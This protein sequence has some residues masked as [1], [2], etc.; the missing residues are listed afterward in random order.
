MTHQK[1]ANLLHYDVEIKFSH[2]A[3]KTLIFEA[4]IRGRAGF[5]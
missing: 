1:G 2:D 5:L 3:P 4:L